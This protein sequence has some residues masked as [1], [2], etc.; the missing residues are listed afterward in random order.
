MYILALIITF[1]FSIIR[2]ALFFIINLGVLV[3]Y[4]V[5]NKNFL[6]NKELIDVAN[7]YEYLDSTQCDEL[8]NILQQLEVD[9]NEHYFSDFCNKAKLIFADNLETFS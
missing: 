7:M 5:L 3:M 4:Y 2:L 8:N 6:N 1:K 9:V